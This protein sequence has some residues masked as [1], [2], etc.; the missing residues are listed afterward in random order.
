MSFAWVYDQP[1][2]RKKYVVDKTKEF[3]RTHKEDIDKKELFKLRP[4]SLQILCIYY[5]WKYCNNI[6]L[7]KPLHIVYKNITR[8]NLC[9]WL[10]VTSN[11]YC[12]YLKIPT[13]LVDSLNVIDNVNNTNV[14][15]VLHREE[16][17]GKYA[18]V[19]Y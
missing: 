12:Y 17:H 19:G 16:R 2:H 6:H 14:D 9:E 13:Y 10:G 5:I 18:S 1:E 11:P 3:K 8:Y 7:L 4:C 15:Y